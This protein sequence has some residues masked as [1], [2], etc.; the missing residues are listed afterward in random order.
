MIPLERASPEEQNDTRFSFIYYMYSTFLSDR[1]AFQQCHNLHCRGPIL[2]EPPSLT[3]RDS[4]QSSYQQSDEERSEEE[5]D[6]DI[7]FAAGEGTPPCGD[8]AVMSL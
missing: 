5:S 2:D 6:E 8:V 1:N 7:D 4:D 3:G